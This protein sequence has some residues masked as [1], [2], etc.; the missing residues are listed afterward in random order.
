MALW[1]YDRLKRSIQQEEFGPLYVLYGDETYLI[2]EA[3]NALVAGALGDSIRDFNYDSFYCHGLETEQVLDVVGTLPMMASRRVVVLK[4]A[5]ALKA[6]DLEALLPLA[7]NP[8]S[9]TTLILT[10]TKVDQRLKFFK[11]AQRTGA[12]VKFDRPFDNQLPNWIK[13]IAGRHQKEISGDAVEL[14]HQWVGPGLIEIDGE[15]RKLAQFLGERNR[16]EISDVEEVVTKSRLNSVFALAHAIGANDRS[17]ALFCLAQLL[18]HGESS[19]GILAMIS[20]HFRILTLIKD[21]SREGLNSSQLASRAGVPTFFLKDYMSQSREWTE[22]R[23][24]GAHQVLLTTDKA[25]KSSPLADHIWLEN[26]VL[27]VCRV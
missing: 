19:V 3:V 23:L 15:I 13:Y 2:E 16:I 8:I 11:E 26:F 20:R 7:V 24:R 10:G 4:E 17:G 5:Q 1:D 18:D 6:K 25:L 22:E 9:S 12:V 14:I 27:S 21:G